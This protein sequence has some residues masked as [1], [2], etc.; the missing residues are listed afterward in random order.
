MIYG[1]I[2]ILILSIILIYKENNGNSNEIF[3]AQSN[4]YINISSYVNNDF[5]HLINKYKLIDIFFSLDKYQT[6]IEKLFILISIIPFIKRKISIKFKRNNYYNLCQLIYKKRS[7]ICIISK[8]DI[9]YIIGNF[10]NLI[11]Y[12]WEKIP[13]KELI[14]YLRYIINN[15]YDNETC[16]KLFDKALNYNFNN[17]IKNNKNHFSYKDLSGLMS[18][19]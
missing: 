13:Q 10:H 19:L 14:Y 15:Y 2:F 5:F 16:L 17:Y 11:Y 6:K 3:I 18:K 9:A 12:K 4:D 8:D 1:K 7:S